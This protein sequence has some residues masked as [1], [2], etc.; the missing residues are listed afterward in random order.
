MREFPNTGAIQKKRKQNAVTNAS[1]RGFP[2]TGQ[3]QESPKSLEEAGLR[4]TFESQAG[5][6]FALLLAASKG[7]ETP[8]PIC[9]KMLQFPL[10]TQIRDLDQQPMTSV[11][12]YM[13]IY[14]YVYVYTYIYTH[15]QGSLYDVCR[16]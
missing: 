3:I 16:R 12:I 13:Y 10:R 5:N 14:V 8:S 4:C 11:Y 2:N 1:I 7:T 9:P 6:D 15:V